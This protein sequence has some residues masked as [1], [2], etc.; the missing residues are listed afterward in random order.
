MCDKDRL[1]A[2]LIKNKLNIKQILTMPEKQKNPRNRS[3][4]PH[5]QD[6][7]RKKNNGKKLEISLLKLYMD[8]KISENRFREVLKQLKNTREALK[9][10]EKDATD[11]IYHAQWESMRPQ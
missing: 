5:R 7:N 9:A 11:L 4:E 8:D 6:R 2:G 1:I 3:V 10:A